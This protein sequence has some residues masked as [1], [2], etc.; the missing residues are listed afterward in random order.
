MEPIFTAPIAPAIIPTSFLDLQEQLARVESFAHEVQVDIVDGIFVPFTSWPYADASDTI[1]QL[2]EYTDTYHVEVDLMIERPEDVLTQYLDAGVRSVVVHLEG[3]ADFDMLLELKAQ[4]DFR[5]GFSISNDTP[6]DMLTA[7]IDHADYVQLM[8]IA[9]IGSQ[10][11]PF[12]ERVLDTIR[13]L[14]DAHPTLTISIDGSVNEETLPR[15]MDAGAQRCVSGSAIMSAE[16]PLVAFDALT[17]IAQ[18]HQGESA[19]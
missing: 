17:V 19:A 18:E 14:K 12:D 11:Q 4:Y 6:L 5:L 9:H 13:T 8:G 1:A 10:G 2:K 15:L 3:V 16:N 7:V